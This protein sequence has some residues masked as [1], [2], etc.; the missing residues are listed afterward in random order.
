MRACACVRPGGPARISL[1][2][3]LATQTLDSSG[4]HGRVQQLDFLAKTGIL[5]PRSIRALPQPPRPR[6]SQEAEPGELE[7]GACREPRDAGG[8]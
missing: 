7:R 6:G 4:L 5:E 2:K 3:C 8:E 1:Q